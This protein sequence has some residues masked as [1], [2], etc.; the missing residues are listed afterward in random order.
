MS[1]VA[2]STPITPSTTA[3]TTIRATGY[4][5][6]RSLS[7][8]DGAGEPSGGVGSR[9]TIGTASWTTGV[10]DYHRCAGT[11][12]DGGGAVTVT[13]PGGRSIVVHYSSRSTAEVTTSTG[14]TGMIQLACGSNV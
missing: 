3:V 4:N 5:H 11:C 2:K 10:T 6:E 9:T 14:H 13:G 7:R 12:P 8:N 1:V